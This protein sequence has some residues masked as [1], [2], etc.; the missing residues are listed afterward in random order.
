M[1]ALEQ[2]APCLTYPQGDYLGR[3]R[4][5]LAAAPPDVP[6]LRA[7]AEFG[8]ASVAAAPET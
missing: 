8:A 7:F 2:L 5:C 1:K 6:G 3:V 4:A